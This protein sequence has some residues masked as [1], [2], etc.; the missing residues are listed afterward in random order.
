MLETS[1]L[2]LAIKLQEPMETAAWLGGLEIV[3]E[4]FFSKAGRLNIDVP[5]NREGMFGVMNDH[6]LLEK[7]DQLVEQA[8]ARDFVL[9]SLHLPIRLQRLEGRMGEEISTLNGWTDM[10][11]YSGIRWIRMNGDFAAIGGDAAYLDALKLVVNYMLEMDKGVTFVDGDPAL[12]SRWSSINAGGEAGRVGIE[13]GWSM[14]SEWSG[15]AVG[16]QQALN[17]IRIDLN[18]QTDPSLV[19]KRLE[20]VESWSKIPPLVTMCFT[21]STSA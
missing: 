13:R 16:E 17:A 7:L 3:R 21:L 9:Y 4:R 1:R 19:E 14:D 8:E 5:V 11:T 15:P 12:A 6:P 10:A 18:P 2:V 20:E